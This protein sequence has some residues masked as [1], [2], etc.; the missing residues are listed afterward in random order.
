MIFSMSAHLII[1]NSEMLLYF[2]SSEFS[3]RV[4]ASVNRF[5]LPRNL[6]PTVPSRCFC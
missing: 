3:A 4:M 6:L 5:K 2:P 1:S